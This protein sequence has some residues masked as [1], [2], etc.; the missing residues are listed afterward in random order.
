MYRMIFFV[1]INECASNPCQNAGSCLD[2][3][4]GYDC[5]CVRGYTGLLCGVGT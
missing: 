3:V 1:D 4:D 5:N 2:K